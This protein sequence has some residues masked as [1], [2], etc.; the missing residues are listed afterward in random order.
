MEDTIKGSITGEM[1]QSCSNV[2]GTE[3]RGKQARCADVSGEIEDCV[4]AT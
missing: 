1:G 3:S 2:V 4:E